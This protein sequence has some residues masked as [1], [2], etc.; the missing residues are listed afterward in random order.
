M[1]KISV[2]MPSHNSA[3]WITQAIDSVIDQTYKNIELIIIDDASLDNTVAI[4]RQKLS[5]DFA[6]AW[7]IIELDA[8]KG[9]SAAR[10]IGLAASAGDWIQFLDSDDLLAPWKFE[11]QMAFC[12]AAPADVAAVQS[13]FRMCHV[14]DD[15]I[16]WVGPLVRADVD[17]RSPLMCMVGG[18]R[19]LHSAGLAR[20]AVLEQIGGFDES[21]RFWEC[22][23]INVRLAKAGRIVQVPSDEPC[24]YWRMPQGQTYIGGD[25][26]RYR[27]PQVALGWIEQVLKAADFQPLS[28][29]NLTSAERQAVLNDC[30]MWAR[31]AYSRDRDAFRRFLDLAR[32]LDPDILPAHPGYVTWLARRFGYEAAEGVA[33]A[34]RLPKQ[35]ARKTLQQL[36]VRP[37]AALID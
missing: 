18:F 19:P 25:T 4:A 23:E 30:T 36:G 1:S 15:G 14:A 8:N 22:E 7:H 33:R 32:K 12:A 17:G 26:A 24:Y 31:L 27:S 21:L 10:N 34:A 6:G 9:P 20:R 13:P 2:I 29:I 3:P 28:A 5:Q 11:R 37:N 35:L 16:S